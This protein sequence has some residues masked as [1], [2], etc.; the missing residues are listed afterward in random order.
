M[1]SNQPDGYAGNEDC[2]QMSS[3]YILTTLGFYPVNPA[4]GVFDI[5]RPFV[6]EA[7]LNLDN[8]KIFTIKANN[9]SDKNVLVK[10][11]SLNGKEMKDYK[12]NFKEIMDGG[13]LV[14]EM[15]K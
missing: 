12:L 7:K 10:K 4:K 9:L 5:G 11:V 1:Y 13:T 3:W 14:F 8:G 15:G 6:K 2:G